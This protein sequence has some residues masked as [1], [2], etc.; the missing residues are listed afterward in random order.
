LVRAPRGGA[1]GIGFVGPLAFKQHSATVVIGDLRLPALI[2]VG[3]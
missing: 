2:E 1:Q 3:Q